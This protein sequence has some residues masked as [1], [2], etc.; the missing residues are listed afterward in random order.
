MADFSH[1]NMHEGA[2]QKYLRTDSST[3]FPYYP[4]QPRKATRNASLRYHPFSMLVMTVWIILTVALVVLLERS[5]ALGP[6]TLHLP[7]YYSSTGLPSDLLTVFAQGHVPIS[8]MHLCR[9]AASGIQ[10]PRTA[11]RTWI[12]FFW[13]VDMSWSG[14]VGILATIWSMTKLRVLVSPV[15]VAFSV[16]SIV[17]L[18]TPL[19]L[20]HA[21][22]I[23]TI[24]VQLQRTFNPNT[25]SASKMGDIDAY[26]QLA[27]GGAGWATN[28]TVINLFNETTFTP[29]GGDRGTNSSDFF[30]A[31]DVES[32]DTALPGVRVQGGCQAINDQTS[33]GNFTA[34]TAYCK[35]LLTTVADHKALVIGSGAIDLNLNVSYCTNITSFSPL[36][37]PSYTSSFVWFENTAGRISGDLVKGL[38]RCDVCASTGNASVYGR[39][40]TFDNFVPNNTMYQ[41]TQGG[42]PL[43]DPISAVMYHLADATTADSDEDS[44]EPLN[45]LGYYETSEDGVP[46]YVSPSLEGYA[47]AMWRGA[48][49]MTAAIALLSR[50]S[51]TTYPA[52]SHTPVSARTKDFAFFVVALALLGVWFVGMFALTV[53]MW[54]KA[55]GDLL[56]SYTAARIVAG[57]P[58]LVNVDSPEDLEDNPRLLEKFD[59]GN[60]IRVDLGGEEIGYVAAGGR[61]TLS[62]RR[63]HEGEKYNF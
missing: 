38:V 37:S 57:R 34:F 19:V 15:L 2:N 52:T 17:A 47:A 28:L 4:P 8:I 51:D 56:D 26:A 11:P 36:Q 43:L 25:L 10:S 59:G 39:T 63:P 30:F 53:G 3:S 9:L 61:G 1:N 32:L 49:H 42:E 55:S 31:G 46:L 29:V 24:D 5:V 40:L 22:P 35:N 12:E 62:S 58:D 23:R 44:Q 7:W 60:G 13:T 14:P 50:S 48:S 41:S 16:I 21:Y 45:M 27:Q 54:R 18:V 6:T 33:L 20:D